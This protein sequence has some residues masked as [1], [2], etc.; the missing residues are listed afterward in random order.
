VSDKV[1]RHFHRFIDPDVPSEIW[2]EYEGQPLRWYE[3]TIDSNNNKTG[4]LSM[5]RPCSKCHLSKIL[6]KEESFN[7]PLK[8]NWSFKLLKLGGSR[9]GPH[10]EK[11]QLC[12]VIKRVLSIFCSGLPIDITCISGFNSSQ[13]ELDS[14]SLYL[15]CNILGIRII[16]FDLFFATHSDWIIFEPYT[17]I[18]I[19]HVLLLLY[20]FIIFILVFISYTIISRHYPIGLLIDLYGFGTSLP[21]NL[22]VH[23]QVSTIN[24]SSVYFNWKWIS[25]RC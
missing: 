4:H 19:L 20:Y 2:L 9:Y 22:T 5:V 8:S 14:M 12:N 6:F 1:Q 16:P 15:I 24:I 25:E 7:C 17:I 21:W 13:S 18:W 11:L 23:F 3:F 10:L